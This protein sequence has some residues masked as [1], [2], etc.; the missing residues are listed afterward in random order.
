MQQVAKKKLFSKQKEEDTKNEQRIIER[1]CYKK[2]VL[3][4]LDKN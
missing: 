1:R 4:N 3:P 2:Y